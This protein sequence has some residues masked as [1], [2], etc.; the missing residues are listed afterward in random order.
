MKNWL[1]DGTNARLAQLGQPNGFA[2]IHT[3]LN[4]WSI[5]GTTLAISKKGSGLADALNP[6]IEKVRPSPPADVHAHAHAA[7]S[8]RTRSQLRPRTRSSYTVRRLSRR[9]ST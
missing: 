6:C 3:G 8:L 9:R 4:E 2:Y 5:N 1:A 7:D